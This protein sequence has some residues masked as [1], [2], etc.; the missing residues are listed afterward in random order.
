MARYKCRLDYTI[1]RAGNKGCVYALLCGRDYPSSPGC[2][3]PRCSCLTHC[4]ARDDI[5]HLLRHSKIRAMAR[6]QLDRMD[7][8]P[9]CLHP[10]H[11]R[12]LILQ[13][14]CH[15][16]A[17]VDVRY[18]ILPPRAVHYR[19]IHRLTVPAYQRRHICVGLDVVDAGAD[20]QGLRIMVYA[21]AVV[22]EFQASGRRCSWPNSST[23]PAMEPP[24][25][26]A[27]AHM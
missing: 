26:R 19:L 6:G 18:R 13:R 25:G 20:K 14:Q 3:C 10:F 23:L 12:L 7:R 8:L 9:L 21:A 24:S 5:H 27:K 17:R 1:S 22:G 11:H 2:L 16:L 15:V 4:D